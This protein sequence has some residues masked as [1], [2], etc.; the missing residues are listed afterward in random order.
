MAKYYGMIGYV[1]PTE[2][3]KGVW[4]DL[5]IE[6]E[7]YGDFTEDRSN[8]QYGDKVNENITI[9]GKLSI[10]ASQYAITNFQHI[11]YAT[12]MGTAWSVKSARPAYPRLYLTLGEV[13]NGQRPCNEKEV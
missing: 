1:I 10:M 8:F 9:S 3:R 12:Y 13:Y 5:P 4:K 7:A 2:V 6:K 11:R